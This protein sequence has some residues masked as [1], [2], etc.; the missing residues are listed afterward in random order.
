MLKLI[1]NRSNSAGYSLVEVM[2]AMVIMAVV[3]TYCLPMYMFSRI[4]IATAQRRSE[5]LIVT[6]K[7]LATVEAT[8]ISDLPTSG[9]IVFQSPEISTSQK[10][11]PGGNQAEKDELL[12]AGG[13]TYEATIT[14]CPTIAGGSG[15]RPNYRELTI[16][17]KHNGSLVY[18][19]QV[20]I[21][22]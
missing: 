15:C 20:A 17:I 21:G 2:T 12:T 18:E 6:Q 3:L 19:Q 16:N 9:T 10:Y 4:K 14:Y 11:S 22:E 7:I 8:K 13:R 5:A 1:K